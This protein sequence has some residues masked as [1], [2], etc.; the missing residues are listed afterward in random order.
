[1]GL[2]EVRGLGVLRRDPLPFAEIVLSVRCVAGP[3][4]VPRMAAETSENLLGKRLPCLDLW[5][6]EDAAPIKLS[7]AIENLGAGAQAG[8]QA[9][10][11]PTGGR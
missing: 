8:Y 9:R 7:E 11:A 10:F 3:G 2:I 5:P 1:M 4:L 6:L